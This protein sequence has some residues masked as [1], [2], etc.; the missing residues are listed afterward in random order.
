MMT[1]FLD[2]LKQGERGERDGEKNWQSERTKGLLCDAKNP[3]FK[4]L[5]L[6]AVR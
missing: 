6:N 5:V 2:F 1:E 3:P 4:K